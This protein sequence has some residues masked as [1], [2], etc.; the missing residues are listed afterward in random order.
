[1]DIALHAGWT[2]Q[3]S[4]AERL[5]DINNR[6]D[7]TIVEAVAM[8]YFCM[9]SAMDVVSKAVD[10]VGGAALARRLPLE[11][12]YRD[13]RA[14]PIHPISGFDAL[15]LIGKHAFGLPRDVEPRYV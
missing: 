13:V 3:K 14:G 9:R 4:I 8:Q 15:E 10:M 7:G 6:D 1:M 2:W 12:Y 11:R 5:M